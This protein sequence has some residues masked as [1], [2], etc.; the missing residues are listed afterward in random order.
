MA[1][2]FVDLVDKCLL[3]EQKAFNADGYM[4]KHHYAR[5]FLLKIDDKLEGRC[6]RENFYEWFSFAKT[7]LEPKTLFFFRSGSLLENIVAEVVGK[8]SN[9]SIER[10]RVAMV[11]P[12]ELKYAIKGKIDFVLRDVNE[13]QYPIVDGHPYTVNIEM[14]TMQGGAMR[15]KSFGIKYQGAKVAHIMQSS[16]YWQYCDNSPEVYFDEVWAEIK[17]IN[18]KLKEFP[19]RSPERKPLNK[20]KR[21]LRIALKRYPTVHPDE[22]IIYCL[23]RDDFYRMQFSTHGSHETGYRGV[24]PTHYEPLPMNDI[25]GFKLLERYLAEKKLPPRTFKNG[26]AKYPCSYCNYRIRCYGEDDKL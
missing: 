20:R 21:Y 8:Y 24:A 1:F 25:R 22:S 13:T 4:K 14:K 18:K 9:W 17:E 6:L 7:D 3:E 12:P 11:H 16:F 2:N 26:I 23:A 5:D 19:A 10:E 15:N